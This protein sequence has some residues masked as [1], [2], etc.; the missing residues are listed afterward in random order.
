MM[1]LKIVKLTMN[2]SSE[3][4]NKRKILIDDTNQKRV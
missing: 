1:K 4:S 3:K 2:G